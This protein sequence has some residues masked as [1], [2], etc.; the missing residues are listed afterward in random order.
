MI[1]FYLLVAIQADP[2]VNKTFYSSSH[3]V[4]KLLEIS[5]KFKYLF[6]DAISTS[7]ITYVSFLQLSVSKLLFDYF[8]TLNFGFL[9]H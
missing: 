6:L 2:Y 8:K 7:N 3:G 5:Y 4:N 9:R 1:Y